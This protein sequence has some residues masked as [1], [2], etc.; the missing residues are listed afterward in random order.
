MPMSAKTTGFTQTQAGLAELRR[1]VREDATRAAVRVAAK[2]ISDE[3]T[4]EAP[5][6][7]EKTAHS[8]SL[9]P[10]AIKDGIRVNSIR[11]LVD[12]VIQAL[13]GPRKGTR[14]SAHLV[15]YGHRLIKGGKSH[16]G[17]KGPEGSGVL[18]GDV[19]AHPFLRPSYE[20]SWKASIDRF[21]DELKIQLARFLS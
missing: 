8:T 4:Q 19:P 11:K 7:D 12:G 1:L 5:V 16:V 10:R 3:M 13:I 18:I 9:P 6:L 15:E 17:V 2:V 20:V 14:R 21:R